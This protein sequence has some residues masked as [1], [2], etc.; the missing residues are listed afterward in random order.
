[1]ADI[2]AAL[3]KELREVSGA[4][5][6]DCKKALSENDGN[7]E[8]AVDWLRKKGLAAAA[9]KA[10]RVAAEGLVAVVAAEKKAVL[11]EVNSETDFVARNDKFQDF[12]STAAKLALNAA[13]IE[14]LKNAK[15][16]EG[17]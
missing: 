14:A 16:P 13:D 3:V 4:G 15:T 11:V 7:L 8:S 5:M 9:K 12:V 2:T 10:G 6:M 1:M 17:P